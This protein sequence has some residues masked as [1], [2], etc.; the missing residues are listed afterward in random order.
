MKNLYT[1]L[2]IFFFAQTSLA[3]KY[4]DTHD[5]K[6]DEIKSLLSKGNDL[7]GFGGADL[8]VGEL[9][10]EQGLFVGAYGGL[11]VNRS[12]MFGIAGYGL[13]TNVE[14]QGTVPGQ[15]EEKPL[16]LFG[17]YG[18]VLFGPTIAPKNL[19]HLS[20]P[21]FFG[22]GAFEVEDQNY[23]SNTVAETDYVVENS[24]FFVVE[25]GLQVEFNITRYFRMAG[26][27]TFR[28]IS[29]TDLE[30]LEDDDVSGFTGTLSLRFGLF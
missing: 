25:P 28:Y 5:P 7:N 12:Y 19:I 27:M 6:D 24:I 29:G 15:Q 9:A 1:V 23:F 13:V 30:N 2:F 8:K 14:I 20:A 3:Q 22:A 26:G 11:I 21:I 4:I 17:G 16:T 10:G 18:G